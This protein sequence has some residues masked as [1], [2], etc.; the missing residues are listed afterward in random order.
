MS[1]V[2][3]A[4]A[5]AV[6]PVRSWRSD[7]RRCD[8]LSCFDPPVVL[9]LNFALYDCVN[10]DN[11]VVHCITFAVLFNAYIIFPPHER[12]RAATGTE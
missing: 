1:M 3:K 10:I 6:T 9:V 11:A 8:K 4:R 2:R 12:P 5:V 7:N